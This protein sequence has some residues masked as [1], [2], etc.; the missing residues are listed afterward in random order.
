LRRQRYRGLDLD[1]SSGKTIDESM[2]AL[3]G[4]R[5]EWHCFMRPQ[6][7]HH[8]AGA[9]VALVVLAP[10]IAEVLSGFTRLS[11]IPVLI[12][13]IMVWGCGTLIIRELVLRWNGRWP[14]VLA[15][16]AALALAEEL[17]IQQTSLAPLPWLGDVPSYGRAGGVN[18]LYL[19]FMI[20]YESVWVVVVPVKLVELIVPARR[21]HPWVGKRGLVIS[22][23]VFVLGS[24]IAWFVWTQQARPRVYHVPPYQPPLAALLVSGAAILA[25][26]A[27]GY[28]LRHTAVRPRPHPAPAPWALA[29]GAIAL[30]A[31][32]AALFVL[33]F[34]S[35]L[36]LPFIVPLVIGVGWATF[37]LALVA[38]WVS[39]TS[40]GDGHTWA[41]VFGA[42]IIAMF[43]GFLDGTAWSVYDLAAKV[44]LD[45]IAVIALLALARRALASDDRR[46]SRSA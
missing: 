1:S 30:A 43:A 2:R 22:S 38:R 6:V 27:L 46:L 25:L 41:L 34:H 37:A 13:E 31:P 42:T 3:G 32:W 12:P 14:S 11:V 19:L 29:V 35:P 45:V 23:L 18:W 36:G 40:W 4:T 7:A 9:A 26:V 17:V 28:A 15:L 5:I 33:A 39:S 44:V 24:C 21:R 10:V 8:G 16:G 20:G